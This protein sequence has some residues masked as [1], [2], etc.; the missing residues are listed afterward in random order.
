VR[1]CELFAQG[2]AKGLS[3]NQAALNAGLSAKSAGSTGSHYARE[4]DIVA[5]VSELKATIEQAQSKVEA[6][7][8]EQALAGVAEPERVAAVAAFVAQAVR[9]RQYRLT[10]VQDIIDRIRQVVDQ[11]AAG[12]SGVETGLLAQ[13]Q[14][15]V[16]KETVIEYVYDSALVSGLLEA[17]KFGAIEV[18][19]WEDKH[20]ITEDR[21]P[22]FSHLSVEELRQQQAILEEAKVKLDALRAPKPAQVF[23][24]A[25]PGSVVAGNN[26]ASVED[27]EIGG[28]T[29]DIS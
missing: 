23:I 12:G 4:H 6:M 7:V 13:R 16:G 19:D 3:N 21:G 11:R 5:R 29:S 2:L 22:D 24:E 20:R 17:L 15:R 14:R 9:D 8:F 26:S 10:V 18:G 28:D 1:K 27:S 25:A